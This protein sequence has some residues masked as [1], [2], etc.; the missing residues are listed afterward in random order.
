[1]YIQIRAVLSLYTAGR[2]GGIVVDSGDGVTQVRILK[3]EPFYINLYIIYNY[4]FKI[5]LSL[6]LIIMSVILQLLSFINAG[7]Y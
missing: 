5:F 6:Y 2:A 1:M 4:S 3:D 7:I